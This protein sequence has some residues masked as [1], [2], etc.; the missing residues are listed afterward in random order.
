MINQPKLDNK[1]NKYM[2]LAS[3]SESLYQTKTAQR[4]EVENEK[5]EYLE[6]VEKKNGKYLG[7]LMKLV[8]YHH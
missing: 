8:M 3:A 5:K 1:L 4:L 2:Q 7:Q 6:L